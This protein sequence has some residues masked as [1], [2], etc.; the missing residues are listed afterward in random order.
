MRWQVELASAP[1]RI[2]VNAQSRSDAIREAAELFETLL[3][4][5]DLPMR[6]YFI[7]AVMQ[8]DPVPIPN[9]EARAPVRRNAKPN[10]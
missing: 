10:K 9:K 2:E 7:G 3:E 8:T 5:G 4:L 6:G 1:L